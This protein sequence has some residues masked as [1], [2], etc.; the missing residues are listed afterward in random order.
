MV[1]KNGEL[2]TDPIIFKISPTK[3]R[4]VP[5]TEDNTHIHTENHSGFYS[6]DYLCCMYI[7]PTAEDIGL[8]SLA[9][10]CSPSGS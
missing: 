7:N 9:N 6:F 4:S 8:L 10:I 5:R 3:M 2:F 1:G